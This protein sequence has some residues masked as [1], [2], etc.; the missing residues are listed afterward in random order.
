MCLPEIFVQLLTKLKRLSEFT[1][2]YTTGGPI[3]GIATFVAQKLLKDPIDKIAAY[4]YDINGTWVDP[5]V[6]KV[7]SAPSKAVAQ[8]AVSERAD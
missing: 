1:N 5:Q 4:E 3:A 7:G 2:G 8:P 6:S